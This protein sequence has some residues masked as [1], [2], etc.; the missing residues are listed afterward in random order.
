MLSLREMDVF[1]HVMELG[2]ITAAAVALKI[3]QPA[4]SRLIQQAE[5]RLG[6]PL[7]LRQKKRL[8]P[9]T[10]ARTLFPETVGAFVAL[11][12]VQRLAG[13]LRS[14]RSGLLTIAA[15]PALASTLLPLAVQR[16]RKARPGVSVKI[17]AVSAHESANLVAD[18]RADLGLIIGPM[19][20]AALVMFEL[21]AA[22]IGC[23]LPKKHR[24]AKRA[25]LTPADL[26]GEAIISLS[27]HLP[28]GVQVERAFAEANTP[29][30]LA[31]EV[32][33]SAV[34]LALV[35]AD[36]GVAL[37]DGFALQGSRNRDLVLRP[38]KPAIESVARI[39]QPR[40]RPASR[41]AQEFSDI[42]RL[43]ARDSGLA[44]P[45]PERRR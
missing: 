18:Q 44:A 24:L 25:A 29:L 7:F 28:I 30:R 22:R 34:A 17:L 41:L 40:H 32:T 2:S 19:T 15:I 12:S 31:M 43:A 37:M 23:V 14:G 26:Q 4:A 27:R 3:S 13:E 36:A 20:N 8:I 11:D 9:T 1:R 35:R 42:L 10:E 45:V 33:Q 39:L 6:F 5:Q 38:L 16:F 21:C